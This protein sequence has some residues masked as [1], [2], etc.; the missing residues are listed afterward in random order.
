MGILSLFVRRQGLDPEPRIKR[1][2]KIGFWWVSGKYGGTL[3]WNNV[4]A[5]S[6]VARRGPQ[7]FCNGSCNE[8]PTRRFGLPGMACRHRIIGR[9]K[10][11]PVKV[12]V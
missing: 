8:W 2:P 1:R 3:N 5:Y 11:A 12:E 4:L 9:A 7:S 6:T 10:H